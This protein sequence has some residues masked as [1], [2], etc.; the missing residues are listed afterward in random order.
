MND[1]DGVNELSPIS[2]TEE[3]EAI[4]NAVVS[5]PSDPY[6]SG[7]FDLPEVEDDEEALSLDDENASD[8]APEIKLKP[9]QKR[10]AYPGAASPSKQIKPPQKVKGLNSPYDQAASLRMAAQR[11]QLSSM[12]DDEEEQKGEKKQE[13]KD[14]Q[15]EEKSK[16]NTASDGSANPN[17]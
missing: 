7:S 10:A 15:K 11:A 5:S 14:A 2:L 9:S 12:Y 13:A 17:T 8:S 6:P 1:L 16:T 4:E 3:S